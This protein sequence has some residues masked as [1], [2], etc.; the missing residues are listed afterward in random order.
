MKEPRGPNPVLPVLVA[1]VQRLGGSVELT[2]FDMR[3][4]GSRTLKIENSAQGGICLRVM[5]GDLVK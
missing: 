2:G 3:A 5:P 1:L 4:A